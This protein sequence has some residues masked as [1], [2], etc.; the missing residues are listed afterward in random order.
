MGNI[1]PKKMNNSETKRDRFVRIA[2]RRVN[3]I[4]DGLD[5][6][7]KCANRKNYQYTDTDVRKIF[8]EI[9]N[10]VKEIKILY[11]TSRNSKNRF[12]LGT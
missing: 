11:K 4:L 1:L 7:G 2:E 5:S 10:K 8:G 9:E 3:K 12:R 6:L